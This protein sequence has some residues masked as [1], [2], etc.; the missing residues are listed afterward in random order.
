MSLPEP[1]EP[2]PPEL[3]P[4][5]PLLEPLESSSTEAGLGADSSAV[6]AGRG[7]TGCGATVCGDGVITG[8]T[9]GVDAGAEGGAAELDGSGTITP[10][11]PIPPLPSPGFVEIGGTSEVVAESTS[12]I[13]WATPIAPDAITPTL[14]AEI[15]VTATHFGAGVIV[16]CFH[17]GSLLRLR[18]VS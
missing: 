8:S 1:L 6:A 14:S 12:G 13:A 10:P 16:V 5:D 3:E 15:A 2:E 11:A 17:Q 9:L 18:V 7:A 4:L